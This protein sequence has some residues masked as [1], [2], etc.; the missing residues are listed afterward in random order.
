MAKRIFKAKKKLSTVKAVYR[1]WSEWEVGDILVGTFKGTQ[2]DGYEKDNYLIEVEDAFFTDK[3]A[4]KKLTKVGAKGEKT[5]IGLNHTGK[6]ALAMKQASVGDIIQVEYRGLDTIQK[7][8][9]KG[10]DVHDMDVDIVE[11]EGAEKA[12]HEDQEDEDNFESADESEDDEDD[13]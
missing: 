2:I 12:E 3:A 9:F 10:K 6:L 11:E 1:K 7:G 5:V 13:L 4:Q 8:K